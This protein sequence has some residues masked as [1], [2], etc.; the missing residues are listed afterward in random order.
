MAKQKIIEVLG[1][2]NK[3]AY[4]TTVCVVDVDNMNG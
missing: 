4:P 2:N 3:C 1:E